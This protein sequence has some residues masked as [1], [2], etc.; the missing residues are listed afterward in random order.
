[1]LSFYPPKLIERLPFSLRLKDYFLPLY[2]QVRAVLPLKKIIRLLKLPFFSQHNPY[3]IISWSISIIYPYDFGK[4]AHGFINYS[5]FIGIVHVFPL[6][7]ERNVAILYMF[8]LF[9]FGA[10]F[11]IGM[12]CLK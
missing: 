5:M 1:M 9:I 10:T 6:P 2:N 8:L 7:S 11:S 12:S 3:F 4:M